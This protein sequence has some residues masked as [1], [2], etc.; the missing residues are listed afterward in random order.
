MP[1]KDC[2]FGVGFESLYAWL[3]RHAQSLRL[4]GLSERTRAGWAS[5][6]ATG[7]GMRSASERA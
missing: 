4:R 5:E 1:T 2:V 6:R 3:A 7:G